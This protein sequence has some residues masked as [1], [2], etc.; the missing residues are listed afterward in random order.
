MTDAPQAYRSMTARDLY[1]HMSRFAH[2]NKGSRDVDM[3]WLASKI[4]TYCPVVSA[5]MNDRLD[6]AD[7]AE[8]TAFRAA[9]IEN[10][11][12]AK[13]EEIERLERDL[14]RTMGL[15]LKGAA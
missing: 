15:T 5:A 3:R 6:S 11:I 12:A 9:E 8:I 7:R 4:E 1:D 14:K 13:R 2:D 10:D